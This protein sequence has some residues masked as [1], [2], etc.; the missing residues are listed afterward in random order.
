MT[1]YSLE[2][3]KQETADFVDGRTQGFRIRLS[4]TVTAGFDD[5]AVF[6]FQREGTVDNFSNVCSVADMF[7]FLKDTPDPENGWLRR[8]AIDL[9]FASKSEALETLELINVDIKLL[10]SEM[11]KVTDDIGPDE[12]YTVDSL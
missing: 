4:A 1:T 7:D 11:S 6:L 12:V 5:A 10:C 2:L 9:V 3:T 8:D